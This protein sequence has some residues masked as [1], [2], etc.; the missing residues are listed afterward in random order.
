MTLE[1][2]LSE[3]K[4]RGVSSFRKRPSK[5]QSPFNYWEIALTGQTAT[6]AP[7]S[8]Q[9]SGSTWAFPSSM[10]MAET[11]QVPTQ[12]SQPTQTSLSTTAFAIQ[13]SLLVWN[14]AFYDRSIVHSS[15]NIKPAQ[16]KRSAGLALSSR[17]HAPPVYR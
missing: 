14:N 1:G 15:A 16:Q 11:G 6:Q 8:T 5:E 17:I 12:A 9:V 2:F 3:N 7:H 4:K 10:L 13:N